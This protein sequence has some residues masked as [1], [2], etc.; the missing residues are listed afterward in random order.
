MYNDRPNFILG[1]HGCDESD[2]HSLLNSSSKI[3]SSKEAFD[4]LG[5]GMYFWENN[6]ERAL[7]WAKDKKKRGKLK[8]PAVIGAIIQPGHC[9]DFT[10]T[11]YIE[12]IKAY[13]R[14]LSD[15]HY[16][17]GVPLP[18]NKDVK[19]DLHKDQLM[20]ELDCTTIEFMHNGILNQFSSDVNSKGY[21]EFRLFDSVKGVFTEGGPA[22][23][24]A[25][26]YNKSHI[27]ICVRNSNC[28]KGFFLPRT[29]AVW[30]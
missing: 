5:H 2:C 25:G 23:P 22:F 14:L 30:P 12:V 9:C 18:V 1:F 20:R 21:S 13:Y 24:G 27:Q 8:N 29:K 17:A 26:I 4:W 6:Y 10:D 15:K 28:I 7:I 3:K 16:K 11:K 19:H